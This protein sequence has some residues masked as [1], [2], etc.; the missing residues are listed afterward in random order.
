VTESPEQ[1][2]KRTRRK[3]TFM[4]LLV[5]LFWGATFLWMEQ[6]TD[7]LAGIYGSETPAAIGAFFL[8]VRF[9]IAAAL[10]PVFIPRCVK[11]LDAAA[12]KLG[13]WVSLPFALGFL[14]QIF[15]LAQ[16]D[17][18]P[19]QSAFLTSLYVVATPIL[20]AFVWRK[21]PSAGVG[22]GVILAVVGAAFMKGP[23]EGGL[24]IGAWATI[25]CAVVFGA[26]ILLTD[27]ATKR[28]DPL[29]ITLT[30]LLWSVLWT[31]LAL[32]IAPGGLAMFE[33]ELL[34]RALA[35]LTFVSTELLCAVFATVIALS[36]L[37]RWQKELAPSRAAIIYTAEPV[38]AAIISII[39]GRDE[40][41]WWLAFGASM[42]VLANLSA[43]LI[44]P[45]KQP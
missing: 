35:D 27:Y 36:V 11:R 8:L 29:A 28:A 12:W 14:L 22:L 3:A 19:S 16:A 38:F 41:T 31:G 15:G 26:H 18:P 39:A 42:I 43:E 7:A 9:V 1:E 44:K 23:P 24:S 30:M 25:G 6:G 37:N 13:F 45:K 10:M 32:V 17:V 4:L 33:P 20:A 40:V 34:G 2:A 5:C 21:L